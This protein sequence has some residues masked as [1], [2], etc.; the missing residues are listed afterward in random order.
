MLGTEAASLMLTTP[1]NRL[2]IG[3]GTALHVKCAVIM[4]HPGV[5]DAPLPAS[6]V[7]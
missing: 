7:L 1:E 6:N 2:Q 4:T 5:I 3:D